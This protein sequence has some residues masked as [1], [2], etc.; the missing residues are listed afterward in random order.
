MQVIVVLP[1]VDHSLFVPQDLVEGADDFEIVW[2]N[3]LDESAAITFLDKRDFFANTTA[4]NRTALMKKVFSS[5]GTLPRRLQEAA[6]HATS[7]KDLEEWIDSV[8]ANANRTL[9]QLLSLNLS[10]DARYS[11]I[12]LARMFLEPRHREG[13][14]ADAIAKNL[15]LTSRLFV[16]WLNNFPAM[17]YNVP[18]KTFE[19]FSPAEREAAEQWVKMVDSSVS[20]GWTQK[21]ASELRLFFS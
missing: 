8:K 17:V 6:Q 1:N 10:F 5:V 9:K 7:E 21:L 3:Q 20:T 13:V 19:F 18:R 4:S 14:P 15:F 12:A 11:S 2:V 16:Y